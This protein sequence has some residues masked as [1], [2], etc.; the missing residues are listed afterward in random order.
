MKEFLR[1]SREEVMESTAWAEE[2]K[3]L[4]DLLLITIHRDIRRA[5]S[6]MDK[7][8]TKHKKSTKGMQCGMQCG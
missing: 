3:S 7:K 2:V 4:F 6:T 5:E 1:A 8:S